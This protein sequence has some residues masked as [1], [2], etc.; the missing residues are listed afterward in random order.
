MKID[1]RATEPAD[2]PLL[3]EQCRRFDVA[4]VAEKVETDDDFSQCEAL[5]FDYF[6]GYLLAQPSRIPGRA[7]D[8]GRLAQLRM[9][10]RL[11][12]SEC[13]ISELEASSEA[14]RS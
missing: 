9:A 11:L 14:I 7:L 12:D 8:P 6:Q 10:A 2:L 5:G 3:V 4:L 13:P 1:L